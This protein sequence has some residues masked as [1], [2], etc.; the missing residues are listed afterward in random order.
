MYAVRYVAV[1][2]ASNRRSDSM[3]ICRQP[4]HAVSPSVGSMVYTRPVTRLAAIHEATLPSSFA[5]ALSLDPPGRYIFFIYNVKSVGQ[6]QG[7][8]VE[9]KYPN[10]LT[11]ECKVAKPDKVLKYGTAGEWLR[12]AP[13]HKTGFTRW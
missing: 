11:E 6:V 8:V 10:L 9:K 12:G 2:Y 13:R 1:A 3:R 7:N 5:F 4:Q